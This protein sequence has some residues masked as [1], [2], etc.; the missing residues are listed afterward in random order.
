MPGLTFNQNFVPGWNAIYANLITKVGKTIIT[1]NRYTS[2]F[3]QMLQDMEVGQYVEDIHINP[4]AAMLQD[5][6][7]NSDIFTDY[8]DDIATAIYEVDVDLVFPSTYTEYVIRTSFSVLENVS[9]LISALTANIRT[10]LEYWRN[11]LVKQ[12]LYNAYQYG[13]MSAVTVPD[14]RT[15]AENSGKFA[16]ALNTLIDDFR[17]E[18][19]PRNVIYNNQIGITPA[20]RRQTIATDIPYVVIFNEYIREAE[21]LNTMNLAWIEKFRSGNNN[22]DWQD[23]LIKLNLEDFPTSIPP[24]NRSAV[25]GNDKSAKD[26]NFFEMPTD[27]DGDPLF[28]NTPKGG[29]QICAFVIEPEAIKLFTQLSVQTAWL[30]PATLRNT[31]REIYRGIMQLG[32]FNKICAVTTTPSP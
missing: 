9:E 14:P 19:N 11:N 5:T 4:G 26:V 18:I 6:I 2:P 27:K 13:M 28:D 21:F 10:T 15:S 24:T 17:T 29:T 20:A 7:T 32:A 22:Q 12:M 8:I 25:S 30:N 31:N 1:A 16:I 23:K 3:S